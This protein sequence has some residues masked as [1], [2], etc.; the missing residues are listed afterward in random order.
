MGIIG[1][2]CVFVLMDDTDG[3]G[4]CDFGAWDGLTLR[5]LERVIALLGFGVMGEPDKQHGLQYGLDGALL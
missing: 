4:W 1:Y 2:I 3:F 5:R